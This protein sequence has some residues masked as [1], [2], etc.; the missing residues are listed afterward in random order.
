MQLT[1]YKYKLF[2]IY[3]YIR[4]RLPVLTFFGI[5][6]CMKSFYLS[7]RTFSI[8]FVVQKLKDLNTKST[9]SNKISV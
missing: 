4:F 3:I 7:R 6:T 9:R 8:C 5:V 1:D 2:I